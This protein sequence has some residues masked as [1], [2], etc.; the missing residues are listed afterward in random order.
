M[1]C[2][3]QPTGTFFSL[4]FVDDEEDDNTGDPDKMGWNMD[5]LYNPGGTGE[6]TIPFRGSNGGVL[7]NS[8]ENEFGISL[9]TQGGLVAAAP[10]VIRFQGARTN[11]TT[12]LCNADVNDLFAGIDPN[13][14]TPW[15]DHPS[16]F[17]DFPIAPNMIRF[18]VVFDGTSDGTDVPGDTLA[19]V[20]GLTNLRV[21]VVPD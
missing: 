11:G 1:S 17:N 4:L 18:A 3:L 12:D 15:V 13:S 16:M 8:W 10:I 20:V 6:I 14:V 2:W 21:R 19:D 7:A 5:I 9:G